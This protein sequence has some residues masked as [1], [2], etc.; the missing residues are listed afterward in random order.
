MSTFLAFLKKEWMELVRTGR[1][2]LLVL[3]FLLFGIMNPAIAKITPWLVEIMAESMESSGLT[4]TNVTVDAMTSWT[5]FYKNI[6]M[7]LLIFV[8]L[9]SSSFS[10]E[11]QK[12][13]FIAVMTKGFARWKIVVA[14]ALIILTAWTA[15]Y[16]MCFGITYGY[17]AYFW[18][19]EIV[20]YPFWG[21]LCYWLFGVCVLGFL[22]LFASLSSSNITASLGT[23][24]IVVLFYILEFF[25]NMKGHTPMELTD[26][27]PLLAGTAVPGNYQI[28]S[29]AAAGMTVIC[30]GAAVICFRK[31]RI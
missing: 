1:L 29:L 3:I 8:L 18:D 9:W 15:C 30:V 24:A 27:L 22:L 16:W 17:N 12:G 2:L 25:P 14:K 5:Q 26:A 10:A 13:T 31:K 19:N 7:A 11:H 28:P 4:V 23:G 6:P 21:A 20:K